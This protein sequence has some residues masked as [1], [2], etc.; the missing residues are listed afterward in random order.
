MPFPRVTSLRA[1][2]IGL[3]ALA[4]IPPIGLLLAQGLARHRQDRAALEDQ[5][6]NMARLAAY[7][8]ERRIEGARQ[9]LVALSSNAAVRSAD[10]DV[11]VPAVRRLVR[12]YD[13]IYT[14]IGW[15]DRSGLIMC[16]ALEGPPNLSIADRAYFQRPLTTKAFGVGDLNTGKISGAHV[17]GFGHPLIDAQGDVEGVLFANMNVWRL[18]ASLSEDAGG[19]GATI[20]IFDR[21]GALVARSR[22]AEGRL[23]FRVDAGQLSLMRTRQSMVAELEGGDGPHIFALST[24]VDEASDPI[25]FVVYRIPRATLMAGID[26]RFRMDL[27][28]IVLFGAG[29][30]LAAWVGAE[31]LVRRPIGRLVA[32]TSTLASGRLDAR[33]GDVGG[34]SELQTLANAFN[35][36]A[37]TLQKRDVHL[38]EGQRLEALGRLAGGIAHDFNNLLTVI[39]GYGHSLRDHVA[40]DSKATREL[41]ELRTAAERAAQLTRQLLAFSRRQQLQP[42][43]VFLNDAVT[44]METLLRRTLGGDVALETALDPSLGMVRADPAQMEQVILNLVINARDAM[45]EGGTVRLETRNLTYTGAGADEEVVPGD[46]VELSVTDTGSGMDEATRTR[47]FEPFF[48]TKGTGG[49]GLGLATV[50]GIVMQSGGYVTCVSAPGRG[51]RFQ[52]WLPRTADVV[53]RRSSPTADAPRGGTERIL[54]VED[55]AAVRHLVSTVLAQQGYA[56]TAAHDGPTALAHVTAGTPFDLL[57]SDVRMPGMSGTALYAL[58]LEQRPGLPAVMMSG[59]SLPAAAAGPGLPPQVFLQ[60]PF[61]PYTLL[62]AVR[63]LLDAPAGAHLRV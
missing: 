4:L 13:G 7:A 9:L 27:L 34:A 47:I 57:V 37:E 22:E 49:T 2:L 58:I 12:D 31:L 40:R 20:S 6:L 56:V 39:L 52:I 15:A 19:E 50:Y 46:Y 1:R 60:K 42:K 18:S 51:T 43:P 48:T 35:E 24:I 44:Q 32:A 41:G 3:V 45:P 38:R 10:P 61:T 23:G 63:S 59:D 53:E 30:M 33:A 26:A 28:T 55:E 36:M 54:L 17:L 21:M 14:E 25:F 8:Q 62:R 29:M 5:A 11:C 16:H